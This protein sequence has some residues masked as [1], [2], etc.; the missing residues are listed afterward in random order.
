MDQHDRIKLVPDGG[1]TYRKYSVPNIIEEA[2]MVQDD[3]VSAYMAAKKKGIPWSS[4]KRYLT[5]NPDVNSAM[6]LKELGRPFSLEPEM[7]QKVFNYLI[8]MQEVGFGLAV[9]QAKVIA[10]DVAEASGRGHF[11]N[12]QK[13]ACKQEMVT[14]SMGNSVMI[15]DYFD[16]L[17]ETT[18]KLK[19]QDNMKDHVWN[20]DET[21]LMHVVK[22]NKVV[23]EIGKKFIY[24]RTYTERGETMT[25]F[26]LASTD[27]SPKPMFLLMDTHGA[28]VAPQVIEL[29]KENDVHFLTF[30][31]HTTHVL[32]PLDVGVYKALKSPWQKELNNYLAEHPTDK[33]NKQVIHSIFKVPFIK[34]MSDKNIKNA[35]R[36][37]G[38]VP[39]ARTVIPKLFQR[40]LFLV[41]LTQ[42]RRVQRHIPAYRL[43]HLQL[44]ICCS[45]QQLVPEKSPTRERVRPNPK[46]KLSTANPPTVHQT[47]NKQRPQKQQK[48]EV[49]HGAPEPSGVQHRGKVFKKRRQMCVFLVLGLQGMVTPGH[50]A[51]AMNVFTKTKKLKMGRS[52]C[53]FFLTPYHELCQSEPVSSLVYTCVVFAVQDEVSV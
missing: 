53:S 18:K 36:T 14:A 27:G 20:A 48:V 8:S 29:A 46:A 13:K 23:A 16:K 1:V 2:R 34:A 38:I 19:I 12:K 30:P 35:F 42:D 17:S 5:E 15:D 45:S 22:P 25:L 44:T 52:G 3:H 9:E 6:G 37:R 4:L 40:K 41:M 50:V 31:P 11:F 7:E 47:V 28:H 49:H 43:H 33:S 39:S 24:S 26:F 21:G 32:Q 51:F 10:F